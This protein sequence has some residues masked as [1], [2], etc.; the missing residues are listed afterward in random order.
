MPGAQELIE[1][2]VRLLA[3]LEAI[4]NLSEKQLHDRSKWPPFHDLVQLCADTFPDSVGCLR[5]GKPDIESARLSFLN[6]FDAVGIP[7]TLPQAESFW[8]SLISSIQGIGGEAIYLCP[9]DLADELPHLRF[10]P[11]EVRAF[12]AKELSDL[13]QFERLKRRFPSLQ[14]DVQQLSYFSWLVVREPVSFGGALSHRGGFGALLDFDMGQDFGAIKPFATSWPKIVDLAVFALTLQNWEEYS[15]HR[16][17]NW[18]A[19]QIPWVYTVTPD[20][21]AAPSFPP[22]HETLSWH[23]QSAQTGLGED[24]EVEVPLR[25]HAIEDYSPIASDL[26]QARWGTISTAMASAVFNPTAAH[27]M[28]RA[29]RNSGIDEFLSHISAVEAAIGIASDFGIGGR[30]PRISGNAQG[31]TVR[32]RRR[33]L[34]LLGDDD[35]AA[36]F[37][38]LFNLRSAYLHGRLQADIASA[39]RLAART[40][41]RRVVDALVDASIS[42]QGVEREVYLSGLC[43]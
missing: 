31:A 40:I 20:Y 14:A 3:I 37:E 41:A 1:F 19:F 21:L 6:F 34:K 39:D 35:A 16:Q 13:M 7:R 10:G 2:R 5:D 4:A 18:R 38:R 8:E 25:L 36:D 42:N 27:F 28:V 30:P 22:S 32:L 24:V 17:Y 15:Q 23:T 12:E 11:C 26:T 33:L 29:F 43:P 9:L